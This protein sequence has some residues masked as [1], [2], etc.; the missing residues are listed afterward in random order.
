MKM[1]FLF[2]NS[3]VQKA[4]TVITSAFLLFAFTAHGA[5]VDGISE[6]ALQQIAALQAEKAS[7]TPAQLK[8]DSQLV[9]ALK[10]SRGEII[11]PGVTNL[12]INVKV[13]AKGMVLVDMD[14]AVTGAIR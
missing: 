7:R 13:E 1:L 9:Y 5:V 8:M 11:A 10:Q 6:S 2:R 14:A 4:T 12:V 3:R